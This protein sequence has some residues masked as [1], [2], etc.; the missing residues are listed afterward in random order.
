MA[1]VISPICVRE[2][3]CLMVSLPTNKKTPEKEFPPLF[4]CSLVNLSVRFDKEP[5]YLYAFSI[6]FISRNPHSELSIG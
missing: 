2:F 4:R 3:S 6:P 5:L 1:S